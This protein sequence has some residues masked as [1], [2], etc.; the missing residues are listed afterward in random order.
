MSAFASVLT[1]KCRFLPQGALFFYYRL[2][3]LRLLVEKNVTS[4]PIWLIPVSVVRIIRHVRI[5]LRS[6]SQLAN[7]WYNGNY[8]RASMR[9]VKMFYLLLRIYVSGSQ[10][11]ISLFRL[12]TTWRQTNSEINILK[13]QNTNVPENLKTWIPALNKLQNGRK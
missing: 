2:R 10:T 6:C 1:I 3:H 13:T 8:Q 5:C 9:Q 7:Y 12:L 4:T 11:D